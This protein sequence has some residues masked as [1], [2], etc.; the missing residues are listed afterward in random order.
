MIERIIMKF[1]TQCIRLI[2]PF[3]VEIRK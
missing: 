3:L 2:A 1:H